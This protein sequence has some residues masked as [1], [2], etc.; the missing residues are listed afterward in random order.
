MSFTMCEKDLFVMPY[1]WRQ[2]GKRFNFRNPTERYLGWKYILSIIPTANKSVFGNMSVLYFDDRV[3]WKGL[4][5]MFGLESIIHGDILTSFLS[6]VIRRLRR[7]PSSEKRYHLLYDLYF[8]LQLFTANILTIKRIFTE[9]NTK[10]SIAYIQSIIFAIL[11]INKLEESE[12]YNHKLKDDGLLDFVIYLLVSIKYWQPSHFTFVSRGFGQMVSHLMELDIKCSIKYKIKSNLCFLGFAPALCKEF[13]V[14]AEKKGGIVLRAKVAKIIA[15][16]VG[17]H[18]THVFAAAKSIPRFN[19]YTSRK[20]ECGWVLCNKKQNAF[21]AKNKCK[22]CMMVQ[23]C[24][25][26]HQKKHWKYI[27]SQQCSQLKYK[28]I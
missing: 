11:S 13:T 24:C 3:I 5:D 16:E 20:R 15:I 21:G 26:R 10:L 4:V 17:R 27:H 8:I 22:G 2:N 7:I 19:S 23:Y 12:C 9:N 14:Y 25:R 6:Q 28:S 18:R 1:I